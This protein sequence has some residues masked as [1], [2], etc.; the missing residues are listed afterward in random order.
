M[1]EVARDASRAGMRAI[2]CKSKDT[3]M[4]EVAQ[5]VPQIN[6]DLVEF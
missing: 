4:A 3:C 6:M 5:D 2:I 1:L